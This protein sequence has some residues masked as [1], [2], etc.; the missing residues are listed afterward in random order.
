MKYYPLQDGNYWEYMDYW[1]YFP[2]EEDSSF[3]SI[4][5]TGDTILSNDNC[6]KILTRKS[7]PFNGYIS[8]I[9]ER[10]DSSTACVYRYSTD[11]LFPNSEYLFDSLLAEPGDTFAGS[12]SGHSFGGGSFFQT[13]CL[14]EYEDTI[15]NF[16]TS[17][18]DFQDQS[19]IPA[20]SYTLG[21]GLGFTGSSAWEL[22]FFSTTLRFAK[23]DRS[24]C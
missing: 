6:Y 11:T 22:G 5:V 8:R 18:K 9:Y 16:A 7:I 12:F 24:L 13:V 2:Y 4:R 20:V 14:N 23:I 19:D 17:F 3:F 10:I 21:K 1:N 15:W